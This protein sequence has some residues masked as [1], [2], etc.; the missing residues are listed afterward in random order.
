MRYFILSLIIAFYGILPFNKLFGQAQKNWSG[1]THTGYVNSIC[2]SEKTTWVATMG[3][4]LKIDNASGAVETWNRPNTGIPWSTANDVCVSGRT[5]NLWVAF[6][7]GLY[8]F[9]GQDWLWHDLSVA[10]MNFTSREIYRLFED[11]SGDIWVS[12]MPIESNVNLTGGM[13]RY[14]GNK[15]HKMTDFG[16]HTGLE[17][18]QT[19]DSAIWVASTLGLYKYHKGVWSEVLSESSVTTVFADGNKLLVSMYNKVNIYEGNSVTELGTGLTSV[20]SI[21][22]VNSDYW[23]GS[24]HGLYRVDSSGTTKLFTEQDGVPFGDCGLGYNPEGVRAITCTPQNNLVL[25]T[26]ERVIQRNPSGNWNIIRQS[27]KSLA[28]NYVHNI[29]LDDSGRLYVN[30]FDGGCSL[31]DGNEWTNYTMCENLQNNWIEASVRDGKNNL[32]VAQGGGMLS[33]L[34]NGVWKHYTETDCPIADPAGRGCAMIRTM[35][36]DRNGQVWI[37]TDGAGIAHYNGQTWK[38]YKPEN[39][40]FP[41]KDD[42]FAVS[43]S[44]IEFDEANNAWI[45]T[46]D[47]GLVHF[48]RNTEKFTQYSR[49]NSNLINDL[50]TCVSLDRNGDVWVGMAEFS[51]DDTGGYA[52]FHQGNFIMY[53]YWNTGFPVQEVMDIEFDSLNRCWLGLNLSGAMLVADE[54]SLVRWV[55]YQNSPIASPDIQDIEIDPSGKVW[56][57]SIQG[58]SVFDARGNQ[59]SVTRPV[60]LIAGKLKVYPNPAASVINLVFHSGVSS[61]AEVNIFDMTGKLMLHKA[62]EINAGEN[63]VGLDIHQIPAGVYQVVLTHEGGV[64]SSGLIVE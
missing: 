17:I 47:G 21:T 43:V 25:G 52:R 56:M 1:Y 54:D 10:P 63:L 61:T 7:G 4:L 57:A 45:S 16:L 8:E 28:S 5:G 50:L 30:G 46:I 31:L 48:N 34:Q 49:K 24:D 9:D 37:G 20:S 53:S 39:S 13:A 23:L 62:L 36:V 6:S 64:L 59:L 51:G 3:G 38:V 14:D 15:W 40:S 22:K 58:I 42:L 26:A 35:A 29:E 12:V 19:S 60:R 2:T 33:V 27:D 18:D 11:L 55:H 32:W 44:D 41:K